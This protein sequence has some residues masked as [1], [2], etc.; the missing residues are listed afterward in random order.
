MRSNIT[1]GSTSI[2]QIT[3]E[4]LQK[5]GKLQQHFSRPDKD[6]LFQANYDHQDKSA[7]CSKCEPDQLV[8]RT[9]RDKEP[10]I[11]YGLIASGN[12]VMKSATTRDA[13]AR[14]LNILCFEMEA[15]GLMDQLP[16]LVIRG[17]CDYCD[18]HKHKQWQRYAALT[19]AAYTRVL[20]GVVPLYNDSQNSKTK[21][22]PHWMVP[23]ARNTRFVS[24]QLEI[25]HLEKL[26]IHATSP[27]KVSIHRLGGIGK[28]QIALELA[29]RMR[30]KVPE[31]SIFWVPCI[32]YESVQQAYMNIASALGISDTEPAKINEQVKA[33]L[34][35][36]SAG[37]WLLIF[38]NTDNLEMWTKGSATA[39][40]L[41]DNLPRSENG[42]VLFTSR[43]RKLA[44]RVA[45]PN[46]LSIPNVDQIT[47]TKI[48]EKSLI[49]KDLLHDSDTTTALLEQL[50][51][52]PLAINQA[53]AYINENEIMLSDYLSLLKQRETD[54]AELLSEDFQD[55]GRYDE[56]RNPVL[57]T[58]LISFQQIRDL[59]T[60]AADYLSFMACINPRDIPQSILPTPTS[61]KKKIDALGLLSAYSFISNHAGGSSFRLHRLVHLATRNW[62]RRIKVF[63]L[64]VRRTTQQ[65][66]DIF[67]HDDHNNRVLWRKYLPHALYLM[68]SEEFNNIHCEY[69]DLSSRVGLS[70]QSDGRYN[71]ARFYS[72]I[73]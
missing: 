68:N 6:W 53:A 18:S 43:N 19:A 10:V 37:K 55:D 41:K 21:E 30:E 17:V 25:D 24:R 13:V 61:A 26:I 42:H 5:Q 7:D 23:F 36:D 27:T 56:T 2:E 11:H 66:D 3:S 32:I 12:Q 58:W 72:L 1:G 47:A 45:S 50:E 33:R 65:L 52:L 34:S 46:V 15:A 29:Y 54:A 20:L 39:P 70:L 51:F 63:D 64:W 9:T 57:T 60:L 49:Q 71:E 16:C 40:P 22:T 73:V 35:Q 31:C 28:T 62:M 8:T 38:D 44:V 59:D 4:I 69:V 67:P 48:L 14:E